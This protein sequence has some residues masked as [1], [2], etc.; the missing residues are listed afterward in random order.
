MGIQDLY[1]IVVDDD[2]ET[3]GSMKRACLQYGVGFGV[4]NP[5]FAFDN[6]VQVQRK[7]EEG[8]GKRV[9]AFLDLNYKQQKLT[10]SGEDVAEKWG[11]WKENVDLVGLEAICVRTSHPLPGT[12]RFVNE[13]LPTYY[14]QK[15]GDYGE[16]GIKWLELY[17]NKTLPPNQG[18]VNKLRR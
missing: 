14:L 13:A 18:P 9:I 3:I 6:K 12:I 7:I 10:F 17:C 8:K 4:L 15:N 2:L 11:D 5:T 1:V 16:Q